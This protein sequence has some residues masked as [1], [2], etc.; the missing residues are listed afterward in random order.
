MSVLHEALEFLGLAAG[1]GAPG[2][3]CE[4]GMA[5]TRKKQREL[6]ERMRRLPGR[7]GDRLSARTLAEV[8]RSAAAG[9][10]EKALDKLITG[11]HARG[12]AVSVEEREEL[13]AVLRALDMPRE[14]VDG[15]SGR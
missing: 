7:F 10:W 6:A 15:L 9:Q 4:L 8:R 14:R 13:L 5:R 1:S 12:E 2:D 3:Q 11:L